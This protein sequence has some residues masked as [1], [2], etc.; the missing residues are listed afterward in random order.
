MDMKIK[1]PKIYYANLWGLRDKKYDWLL[2]NNINI[3]Y[4][5]SIYL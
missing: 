1:Q 3:Y 4:F 5:D 2:K